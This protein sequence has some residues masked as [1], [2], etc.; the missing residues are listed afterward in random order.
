M[1]LGFS[2]HF[3]SGLKPYVLLMCVVLGF[4]V[5]LGL[6][7]PNIDVRMFHSI[8]LYTSTA[9]IQAYAALIAIPFT[10][11]VV[12]L[13]NRYGSVAVEFLFRHS[14]RVFII[15]G[16]IFTLSFFI[17][18]AASTSILE[19]NITARYVLLGILATILLLPLPSIVDYIRSLF[20]LRSSN[21][22]EFI[23]R[24][25]KVYEKLD[26]SKYNR[27]KEALSKAFLLA[28]L[29]LLDPSSELE[30]SKIVNKISSFL[31][32]TII[33]YLKEASESTSNKSSRNEHIEYKLI[34]LLFSLLNY[35]VV[36]Y[37]KYSKSQK[38]LIPL[39]YM[40]SLVSTINDIVRIAILKGVISFGREYCYF[41]HSLGEIMSLYIED[42][43]IGEAL[44]LY[45]QI[46]L[47]L[48]ESKDG[49]LDLKSIQKIM[50]EMPREYDKE[51]T[52]P[53]TYDFYID[54]V[55]AIP[56]MLFKLLLEKLSLEDL[57][58]I[59]GDLFHIMLTMLLDYPVLLASYTFREHSCEYSRN[60]ADSIAELILMLDEVYSP[61]LMALLIAW[62][63]RAYI[64]AENILGEDDKE[65]VI[66]N[67]RALSHRL[68]EHLGKQGETIYVDL[69]PSNELKLMF[70]GRSV[71]LSRYV[72]GGRSIFQ[73]L[74]S[75]YDNK[76]ICR[77]L[78]DELGLE[79][80]NC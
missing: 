36:N 14:L 62:I 18:L 12:H 39:R 28:G 11:A 26:S 10:I 1:V 46:H 6:T 61:L 34:L 35:Y 15:L 80:K 50:L 27:L 37:L 30:L 4:I 78:R 41:V 33:P 32:K 67:I 51:K 77:I 70:R 40:Y 49:M 68:L 56:C 58:D 9:L 59:G 52:L 64:V 23:F 44:D 60:C 74:I 38:P 47:K 69:Y 2:Q 43:R 53:S 22:V 7:N 29:S 79:T 72:H 24:N 25:V 16:V 54:Y 48:L 17:M 5:I 45:R 20:I 55:A 71:S 19:Q 21:I 65:Q 3:S 13:Q 42:R 76:K 75:K 63:I 31:D 73:E 57:K 8:I 66:E